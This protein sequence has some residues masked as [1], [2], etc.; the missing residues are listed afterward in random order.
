MVYCKA[1]VQAPLHF[2]AYSSTLETIVHKMKE[3]NG[4]NSTES[5]ILNGFPDDHSLSKVFCPDR[6]EA[7]ENTIRILEHGLYDISHWMAMNQLIMNP[8]KTDFI[9]LGSRVQVG[10]CLQETIS[11]C[12]GIA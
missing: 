11:V 3:S 6:N 9:Y 1:A 12:V 7:E 2:T 5:I 10:K 4:S 8:T